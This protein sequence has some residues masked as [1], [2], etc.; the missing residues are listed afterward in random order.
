M[1][2]AEGNSESGSRNRGAARPAGGSAGAMGARPRVT[3]C[4]HAGGA[5]ILVRRSKKSVLLLTYAKG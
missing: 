5:D 3:G 2:G 1:R 4:G